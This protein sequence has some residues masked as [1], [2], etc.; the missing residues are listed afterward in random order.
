LRVANSYL[1]HVATR[2]RGYR[3]HESE[4]T[5]ANGRRRVHR[6]FGIIGK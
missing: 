2:P 3:Q 4:G 6:G 5:V 1:A